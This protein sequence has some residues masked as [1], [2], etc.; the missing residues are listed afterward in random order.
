[1]T[2]N[3]KDY[4]KV[5]NIVKSENKKSR[6][7]MV[8]ELTKFRKEMIAE[9]KDI[10]VTEKS[11]RSYSGQIYKKIDDYS[12]IKNGNNGGSKPNKEM[13][14]LDKELKTQKIKF[15]G[16]LCTML[17]SLGTLLGFILK[18]IITANT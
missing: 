10:F 11:C 9:M 12:N 4:N 17:I 6:S 5:I 16:M 2:M 3:D 15:Y 7:Q 1:M 18:I 13:N 14:D 8:G